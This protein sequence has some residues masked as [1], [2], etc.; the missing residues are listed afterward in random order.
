MSSSTS[1]GA[2]LLHGRLHSP[3][4][5]SKAQLFLA[6]PNNPTRFRTS[7]SVRVDAYPPRWPLRAADGERDNRVQELRVPDSWLTPAGAAQVRSQFGLLSEFLY[8]FLSLPRGLVVLA[9]APLQFLGTGKQSRVVALKRLRSSGRLMPL[10]SNVICWLSS[11]CSCVQISE[12]R[13]C[14]CLELLGFWLLTSHIC[15][16]SDHANA[17]LC[18]LGC[19]NSRCRWGESKLEINHMA[20]LH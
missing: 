12:F 6:L 14:V 17:F 7:A 18:H 19:L 20:T 11:C 13:H 10:S 9:I 3:S 4:L 15:P 5:P 1:F 16:L 2:L 8:R